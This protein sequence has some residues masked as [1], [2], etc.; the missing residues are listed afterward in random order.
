MSNPIKLLFSGDEL[1]VSS[2]LSEDPADQNQI[3]SHDK[4]TNPSNTIERSENDNISILGSECV[5][6]TC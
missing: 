3:Q 2:T 6:K 4:L 5:A 1:V